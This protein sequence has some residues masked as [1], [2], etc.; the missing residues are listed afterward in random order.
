MDEKTADKRGNRVSISLEA[1]QLNG[2]R[3]LVTGSSRGIGASIA[4]A[5]ARAGADVA[6]HYTSNID[7][8]SAVADQI[9]QFGGQSVVV[10]ADLGEDD[11]AK[12]IVNEVSSALGDIDILVANVSV[13]IPESWNKVSRKHFDRQVTVNWRSSFELIQLV[14]PYML[15]SGWG[16]ILTI[17]S[18]QERCPH[19]DMV[20]YSSL[21]AAQTLMVKNFAKQFAS[22]GVTVNN[23][24]PGVIGTDRSKERLVDE[25]YREK[26]IANIPAGRIGEPEDCVGAA[27]LLCSEAG[28][29]ITG[30][31][32]FVE[33]GMSI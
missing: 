21:K 32:L 27:L 8:A 18:V 20:I 1:F 9:C 16:R 7:A 10:Q 30:Q 33:G 6:V 13:Q 25:D 28:R 19:P 3:A 31:N 4:V 5:L 22:R 12:K 29:Y 14:A 17:G 26:V 23:L 11:S 15:E 24:A 2:R